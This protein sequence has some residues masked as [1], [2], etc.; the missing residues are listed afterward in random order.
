METTDQP[1]P[2]L[3]MPGTM[4]TDSP[5]PRVFI[6]ENH[7]DTLRYLAKFLQQQGWEVR[8]AHSVADALEKLS[9]RPAEVLISDLGLPDGNG[10][11][12]MTRLHEMDQHPYAVAMS[13]FG[14]YADIQRSRQAG[15]R[16]HLTKPFMP[17]DLLSVLVMNAA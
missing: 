2:F 11:E 16:H 13:G 9:A 1:F 7:E 5:K 12:L 14:M 10:W 6:V 17:E 8:T 15:F 3:S 4:T